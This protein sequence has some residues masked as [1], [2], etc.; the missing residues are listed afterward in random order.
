MWHGVCGDESAFFASLIEIDERLALATRELGC[1][2][3]GG[4]LHRADYPRK[5]R[6]IPAAWDASFSW[7][8]SL[9][10][11]TEGCRKRCTPRSVRFFGRRVYIAAVIVV[12]SGLWATARSAR[13]PRNTARRWRRYFDG[14]FPQ[15][16]FWASARGSLMPPIESSTLVAS[17]LCRFSGE[18]AHKLRSALRFLSPVTTKSAPEMM[19]V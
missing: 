2:C 3:C 8:I 15:S 4:R 11:A 6:G 9:C 12:V 13:V 19:A 10:C 5:P 17:L 18:P 1:P 14:D 7:R 16:A